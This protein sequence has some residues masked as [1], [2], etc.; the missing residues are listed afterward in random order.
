MSK[1]ANMFFKVLF[2]LCFISFITFYISFKSGYYEYNSRRKMTFTREQIERFEADVSS[3]NYVDINEYLKY[4]DKG[5]QNKISR[6]T[7][8]VSE[9]ISKYTRKG[10]NAIFSKISHIIEES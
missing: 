5:Y 4:T 8:S 10:I 2:I 6:A 9:M 7:L 1:K 3:G